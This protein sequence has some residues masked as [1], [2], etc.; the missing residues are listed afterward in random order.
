MSLIAEPSA[1]VC[2]A[3]ATFCAIYW[4]NGTWQ[5][6]VAWRLD[7]DNTNKLSNVNF[8]PGHSYEQTQ[9]MTSI[10]RA[11]SSSGVQAFSS[12][13]EYN[14]YRDCVAPCLKSKKFHSQFEFIKMEDGWYLLILRSGNRGRSCTRIF[15]SGTITWVCNCVFA[16]IQANQEQWQSRNQLIRMDTPSLISERASFWCWWWEN[17]EFEMEIYFFY[18][19]YMSSGLM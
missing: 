17:S 11:I 13:I 12:P 1:L 5:W 18:Q 4:L 19:K 3:C 16:N 7:H 14:R 2:S 8:H 6:C 10:L 9:F 15:L